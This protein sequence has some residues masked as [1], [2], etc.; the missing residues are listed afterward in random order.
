MAPSAP[1]CVE[2]RSRLGAA[3]RG[4]AGMDGQCGA[5]VPTLTCARCTPGALQA[6]PH[7]NAILRAAA[8]AGAPSC[9]QGALALRR[10]ACHAQAKASIWPCPPRRCHAPPPPLTER[11]AAWPHHVTSMG[12]QISWGAHR[13]RGVAGALRRHQ[14]IA[15][16]LYNWR[17]MHTNVTHKCCF[18]MRAWDHVGYT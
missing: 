8:L 11:G 6:C 10:P 4:A 12:R 13:C 2:L 16:M 7:P 15:Y 1:A 5:R 18:G 9:C 14:R 17:C 3:M